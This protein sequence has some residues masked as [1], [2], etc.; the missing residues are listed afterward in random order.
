V[1]RRLQTA[2]VAATLAAL[3]APAASASAAGDHLIVVKHRKISSFGG[4]APQ[5]PSPNTAAAAAVFGPGVVLVDT[6]NLCY[7]SYASEGLTISFVNLGAPGVSACDPSAGK[8]QVMVASGP[9]WRTNRGLAAGD[10]VTRIKKLYRERKLKR[11]VWE[12]VGKRSFIGRSGHQ[13]VLAAFVSGGRV[14]GFKAFPLSAG[15]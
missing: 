14:T 7:V 15:E 4:F 6:E 5:G 10:R 3:L 13:V 8:A 12:L 9:G 2:I 11:G 1:L